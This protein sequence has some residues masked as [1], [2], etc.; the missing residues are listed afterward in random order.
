MT[1][2][3]WFRRLILRPSPAFGKVWVTQWREADLIKP[4]AV[5]PVFATLEKRLV[6]RLLGVLSAE[7]QAALRTTIAATI[8]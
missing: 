3:Q 8:G 4:S 7:D 1:E 6:I 5:K 2:G